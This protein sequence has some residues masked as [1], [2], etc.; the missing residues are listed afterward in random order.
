VNLESH[1]C[2]VPNNSNTEDNS[3]SPTCARVWEFTTFLITHPQFGR[4]GSFR[5]LLCEL[6]GQIST[7]VMN[8]IFMLKLKLGFLPCIQ[9]LLFR[10]SVSLIS[11]KGYWYHTQNKKRPSLSLLMSASVLRCCGTKNLTVELSFLDILGLI[12]SC[13]KLVSICNRFF[14]E[15]SPSLRHRDGRFILWELCRTHEFPSCTIRSF[16]CEN[17]W[18]I[19]LPLP[20]LFIISGA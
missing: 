9:L 18:D 3:C 15:Q 12:F 14:F 6:T 10:F 5:C 20:S 1:F 17:K 2:S 11:T 13:L 19:Q 16:L 4:S 7:V 8:D